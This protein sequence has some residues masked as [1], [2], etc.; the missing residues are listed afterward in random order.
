MSAIS[1]RQLLYFLGGT[2]GATALG[3]TLDAGLL[4][5]PKIAE[6][7]L[8][9]G[10]RLTPLRLPH[11]LPIYTEKSSYYPTG[12]NQ[13]KVFDPATL[14]GQEGQFPEATYTIV[15]DVV[16]AP[17]YER[18][19]I[20]AWGDRVFPNPDDYFGYN[21]DYTTLIGIGDE[22]PDPT[23]GYLWVNH[24]YV[25]FP[26]SFLAPESPADLAGFPTS[27]Q[28]VI[29]FSLPTG[30][31]LSVLSEP[32]R[33]LLLGEFLYNL[34]GSIVRVSSF[35][36]Q[37]RYRPV[38]D[39][40]NRRVHGLSGLGI[41][42]SRPA[43]DLR[44][45]GIPYNAVTTWGGRS[46]QQGD[47]N[48]LVGTGPAATEVFSLSVDK[49]GN[50]IIGTAYNCSGGFTPWGTVLSA[51]ENFQGS[52]L[53]FVGVTEPVNPNGTQLVNPA[54][55]TLD[56]K[57]YTLGT[58]GQ[59]FGLVGEKYGWMV[60]IDPA[61]PTVRRKHTYL[62]RF[63][64]ENIAI[65]AVANRPLIAYM[66]DDRRGGHTWKFVSSAPLNGDLK[67]KANSQ[68]FENGTLYVARLNP[69]GTGEWIPLT[70]AT[71]TNPNAPSVLSSQELAERGAVSRNGNTRFPRRNGIAGQTVEGG[72]FV[73]TTQNEASSLL[74]YQGKTLANFYP[75]Q[76]AI[77]V[78]AF[79]AANLVG[80]TPTGRPEDLEINPRTQEV[81][82]A[83]TDG[84]PG[85]DG[86]PDSRVFTVSKYTSAVND[87][88]Q[89]GGLYKI[90]ENSNNGAGTTFRWE[91]FLQA[92]EAGT[93][94]GTGFANVDN[95][96][97][98]KQGN[99][100]GVTDMSTSLHN[101]FN[102]GAAGAPNTISHAAT[103]D[104]ASLT[105]VFGNNFLFVIP[106]QGA[107]A[108]KFIPFAY[109]PPRCEMTG[110]TFFGLGNTL[111][112]SV[113]HPGEDCPINDGTVLT[114]EVEMLGL[115]GSLI[116]PTPIRQVP[117]GSSWPS[118]LNGLVA[119]PP[120]PSVIGIR[121][122]QR[123]TGSFI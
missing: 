101:G 3:T 41:N 23:D 38:S 46:H 11:P 75:T 39:A 69:D 53:F 88:Q 116:S 89:S 114:R 122:K 106:L 16:V 32:D 34:G 40:N 17:E 48:T 52:S 80:G 21:C 37:G 119:G 15:D 57:G 22:N 91:R 44:A 72:F 42:A 13:G 62:G 92:G 63:R 33:R 61:D 113:Q 68:L 12:L 111:I 118:N 121:R 95:I 117:R 90:I 94:D 47:Q 27:F 105:G 51:E 59:E 109:G 7:Q 31:S 70:L 102:V 97:F 107:D 50:Q 76:G 103:G 35:R 74:D 18:Y 20:V 85:S 71:P 55:T 8:A 14:S 36:N 1:R 65:R 58:S 10:V 67:D 9:N 56:I 28:Q 98:D 6:A 93:T 78:D 79:A 100:W 2:A 43:D 112:I 5:S 73:M 81:F 84:A 64:H 120:R 82:I 29:G 96:V 24:E 108:G 110:P 4:G 25:S 123:F 87:T 77:L 60:E 66:G 99:L 45:D 19:V 49:L 26:F 104:A 86:Y 83:Y 54:D 115:N 30:S